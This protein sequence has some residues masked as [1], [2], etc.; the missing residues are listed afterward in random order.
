VKVPGRQ[1][2][3]FPHALVPRGVPPRS[4]GRVP[5]DVE[6]QISDGSTSWTEQVT[7][8]G[9]GYARNTIGPNQDPCVVAAPQP[10][11]S[12]CRI[13]STKP[14]DRVR[15]T[16]LSLSAAVRPGDLIIYGKFEPLSGPG[17]TT[18]IWVDTVLVVDRTMRWSTSQRQRGETCPREHCKRQIFTLRDPAGFAAQLTGERHGATTDAYRYNLSDAEP[19][20]FHCCTG[21]ADYRVI[22]GQVDNASSAIEGLQTSFAPLAAEVNAGEFAPTSLDATNSGTDWPQF[23]AFIDSQVRVLSAGPHGSWIARF[24]DASLAEMLCRAIIQASAS[25]GQRGIVAMLPVQ[26]VAPAARVR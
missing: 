12:F 13:D 1:A 20:G 10:F 25:R 23:V 22:L 26:L 14:D 8:F 7:I 18:R 15:G 17:P 11:H 21:R 5:F 3:F 2:Y 16:K 4:P 24:P 6:A 9:D 19:S